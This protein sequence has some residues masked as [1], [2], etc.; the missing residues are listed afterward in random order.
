MNA[1]TKFKKGESGNPNGRPP[2]SINK[3]TAEMKKL[4]KTYV[5]N[6]LEQADSLLSELTAKERLDI[7]CKMLPYIMPKQGQIDLKEHKQV[8]INYN[9]EVDYSQCTDEQ[10]K[11]IAALPT[12]KIRNNGPSNNFK[13]T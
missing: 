5:K 13:C 1:N 3:T 7:L 9:D 4:I 12:K 8:T 11:L 2:G 6:E 10:L